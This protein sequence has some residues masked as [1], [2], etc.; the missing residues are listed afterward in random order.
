MATL[1]IGF[2]CL[3]L[4]VRD[5]EGQQVHVVMPSTRDSPHPHV[6]R[7]YHQ[8]LPPGSRGLPLEGFE[9]TFGSDASAKPSADTGS[10]VSLD[11]NHSRSDARD[12]EVAADDP[13]PGNVV[14][15]T[16]LT[17]TA[18]KKGGLRVNR[19]LVKGLSKDVVTIVHLNAGRAVDAWAEAEW[20]FKK[21]KVWMAYRVVWEIGGVADAPYIAGELGQ[22][23]YPGLQGVPQGDSASGDDVRWLEIY[24]TTPDALPP[25]PDGRTDETEVQEHFRIFYERILK[26]C[27]DKSELP[28][29]PSR[30]VKVNCGVSQAKLGS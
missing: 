25:V 11:Q 28:Q 27:P 29:A 19:A 9:L 1:Q 7:L 8:G 4:L 2:N 12:R 22:G 18:A 3:C 15:L 23:P 21:Q 13:V 6:V 5:D 10:L 16:V 20:K 14:D 30:G 17:R 24:H 26:H